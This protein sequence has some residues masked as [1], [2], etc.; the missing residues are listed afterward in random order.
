MDITAIVNF[1]SGYAR[2]R[3]LKYIIAHLPEGKVTS[4]ESTQDLPS[5]LSYC[6]LISWIIYSAAMFGYI[7]IGNFRAGEVILG[8]IFGV[9]LALGGSF[10]YGLIMVS[11]GDSVCVCETSIDP[12]SPYCRFTCAPSCHDT[13]I[14][15]VGQSQ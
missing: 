6:N 3:Q 7:S 11:C 4:T 13:T 9:S 10:V 1:I 12:H 14:L 5:K 2:Y 15:K 8:H